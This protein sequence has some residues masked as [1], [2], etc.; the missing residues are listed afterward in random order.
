[1][2]ANRILRRV[3]LASAV[4]VGSIF[5]YTIGALANDTPSAAQLDAESKRICPTITPDIV[6]AFLNA[7]PREMFGVPILPVEVRGI[8]PRPTITWVMLPG[9]PWCSGTLV[10]RAK[11]SGDLNTIPIYIRISPKP[12]VIRGLA[13]GY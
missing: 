3:I 11:G 2:R 4:A 13:Y 1:M 7:K 10:F 12:G 8:R 5:T 9:G 6:M